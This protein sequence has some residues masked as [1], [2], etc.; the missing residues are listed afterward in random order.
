MRKFL[1]ISVMLLVSCSSYHLDNSENPFREYG[2]K[3]IYIANF[4][5]YSHF[6]NVS[7][8]FMDKTIQTLNQFNG[9]K[10]V[11]SLKKAD[12]VFVGIID[13]PR[14]IN[15]SLVTAQRRFVKGIAKNKV[16][17]RED[18]SV[19]A[20]SQVSLNINVYVVK[21]MSESELDLLRKQKIKMKD[22]DTVIS[23]RFP[24]TETFS[25]RLYDDE[26]TEVLQTQNM[27]AQRQSYEDMSVRY[28]NLLRDSLL[29]AF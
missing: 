13:T 18:F 7:S 9:L 27:G 20:V 29:Y 8:D 22:M 11:N 28:N 19:P 17:K 16:A 26:G 24:L 15:E 12:A 23:R 25:R 10:I 4:F 3:T 21:K 5:N 6:S 14:R 2:I 1:A